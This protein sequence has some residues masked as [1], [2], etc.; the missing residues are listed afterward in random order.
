M[1][2]SSCFVYPSH[3][4]SSFIILILLP[5]M[6]AAITSPVY[7]DYNEFF[8]N[9]SNIL[10]VPYEDVTAAFRTPVTNYSTA[11]DGFDWTQPYPGSRRDGHMAYLEIAQEMSLSA[12]IV[13]NSTTVLSSLTFGI[14]GSMSSGRQ[15]LAMD[16]SWYICRHVFISTRPE[17]K[18][19]V[20]GGTKCDFLSQECQADLKT[21]LTQDWGKAAEGTMCS[22]LGFDP[23]PPSCQESFGFARQDVIAFDAAFL[24]NTTLAP[25]LTNREQQQYSWRIGTGYHNP[26]DASAYALAANRTY[27]VATVWGYSQSAKHIQAPE[28][29]FGCLSSGASYIPRPPSPSSSTVATASPSTSLLPMATASSSSGSQTLTPA[30]IAIMGIMLVLGTHMLS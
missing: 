16:A 7:I 20:D 30:R 27:L 25:V 2:S 5:I 6:A 8:I 15:P 23:I 3:R 18:L 19:A 17:A 11:I 28:V 14:P 10:A 13:E 4:F 26:G 21:S 12:S 9:S 29:S 22:A 1:R 24:A